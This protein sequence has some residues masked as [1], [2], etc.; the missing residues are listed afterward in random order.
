VPA[1][2]QLCYQ[3]RPDKPTP[4]RNQILRHTPAVSARK[5]G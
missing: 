3:V 4:P 5:L 2:Q 1:L